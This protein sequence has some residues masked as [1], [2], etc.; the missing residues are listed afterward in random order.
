MQKKNDVKVIIRAGKKIYVVFGIIWSVPL[1]CGMLV[2]YK[3]PLVWQFPVVIALMTT[4]CF[5]WLRFFKIELSDDGIL[6]RTLWNLGRSKSLA[7]T[8]ISKVEIKI[9]IF[10]YSDRF[11]PTVRL[12]LYPNRS[13]KKPPIVINMKVFAERDLKTFFDLLGSK[14]IRVPR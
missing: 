5:F 1:I 6:Y 10:K 8:E 13:V 3:D 4:F 2:L 11:K 14:G 7:F 12:D 9:G